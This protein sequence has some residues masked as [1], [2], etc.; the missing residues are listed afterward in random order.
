MEEYQLK[1]A[2]I[3]IILLGLNVY[4]HFQIVRIKE[5]CNGVAKEL[6]AAA[7][8]IEVLLEERSKMKEKEEQNNSDNIL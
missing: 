3:A 6:R 5:F 8:I 1:L 7:I 4:L 2:I